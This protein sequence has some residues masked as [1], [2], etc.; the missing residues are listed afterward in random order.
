LTTPPDE[1]CKWSGE[2]C[3][4]QPQWML[5]LKVGNVIETK[6][7]SQRIVRHIIRYQNGFIQ[8]VK[9]VAKRKSWCES[10][11][12]YLSSYELRN[13]YN[14]TG[15]NFLHLIT[16]SLDFRIEYDCKHYYIGEDRLK[17]DD[18]QGLM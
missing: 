9:A 10:A 17:Y 16:S 13:Y 2:K 8:Y 12:I 5:N 3:F 15:M 1:Y 14:D 6:K 18:V 11:I 7:G 4:P